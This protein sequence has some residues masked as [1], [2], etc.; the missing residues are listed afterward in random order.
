MKRE[1]I[2]VGH[3]VYYLDRDLKVRCDV[4]RSKRESMTQID[5]HLNGEIKNYKIAV[6]CSLLHSGLDR[7][8]YELYETPELAEMQALKCAR[9]IY[10]RNGN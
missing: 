2:K 1:D 7:A 3:D 4:V 9:E 6:T 5:T 8:D 10:E